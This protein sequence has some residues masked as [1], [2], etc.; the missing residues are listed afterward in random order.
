MHP[1][2]YFSKVTAFPRKL[3]ENDRQTLTNHRRDCPGA[4]DQRQGFVGDFGHANAL[5]KGA[6]KVPANGGRDFGLRAG[7][8]VPRRDGGIRGQ[9]SGQGL[10]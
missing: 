4:G 7:P 3:P 9:D 2:P 1:H 10:R 5:G 8:Q 6:G